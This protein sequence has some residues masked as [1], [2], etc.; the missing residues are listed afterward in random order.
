MKLNRMMVLPV[1]AM[2]VGSLAVAG[3]SNDSEATA[4]DETATV[5][6]NDGAGQSEAQA[7]TALGTESYA[8]FHGRAGRGRGERREHR[9][10]GWGRGWGR[11]ERGER[12][13]R[14]GWWRFW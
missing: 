6:V 4:S 13:R 14:H 12:G 8:R 5:Q 2:M 3:C 11:G 9:G 10:G 1:V 7:T